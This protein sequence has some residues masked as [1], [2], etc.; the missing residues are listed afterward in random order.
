MDE[1]M[2]KMVLKKPQ[3]MNAMGAKNS[4]CHQSITQQYMK[5]R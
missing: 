3:D 2:E 5:I 4:K 1:L